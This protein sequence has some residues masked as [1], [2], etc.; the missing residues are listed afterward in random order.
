[1]QGLGDNMSKNKKISPLQRLCEGLDI[2]V[3]TFGKS[4]FIEAV[5]KR[6]VTVSG[7]EGLVNYTENEVELRLCDGVV[8]ISGE[9]LELQ[10]FTLGRVAV[11]GRVTCIRLRDFGEV[12]DAT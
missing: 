2:P 12:D 8:N 3:G 9:G 7:C 11:R 1:M 5:G 6:E 10:S 4:S